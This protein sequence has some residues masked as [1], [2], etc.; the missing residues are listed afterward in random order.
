MTEEEWLTGSDL[1]AMARFLADRR[2]N[3]KWTLFCCDCVRRASAHLP[4]ELN[5]Y[6]AAVEQAV[7]G[8]VSGGDVTG[9]WQR[10][11][12]A[13]SGWLLHSPSYSAIVRT[14]VLDYPA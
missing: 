4:S 12:R 14:I 9:A 10:C 11:H 13:R 3:R 2:Y 6:V 1:H 7:D 5:E 8:S